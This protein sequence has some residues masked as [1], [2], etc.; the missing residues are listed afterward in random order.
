[1][2]GFWFAATNGKYFWIA[3]G[4]QSANGKSYSQFKIRISSEIKA[5]NPNLGQIW[6][7]FW[8][9]WPFLKEDLKLGL[10]IR[11][12]GQNWRNSSFFW[13][14]YKSKLENFEKNYKNICIYLLPFA[15]Y[16]LLPANL[17]SRICC[18]PF[19]VGKCHV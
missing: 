11:I 13:R 12:L 19:A 8:R 16:D 3:A 15:V 9:I 4:K 17:L 10:R 5:Q 14:K 6:R 7:K 18:L 1:M 2:L